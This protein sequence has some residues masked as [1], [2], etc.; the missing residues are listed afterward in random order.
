[1]ALATHAAL[2]VDA[3]R[4]EGFAKGAFT[5]TA[6][7]GALAPTAPANARLAKMDRAARERELFMIAE[8]VDSLDIDG[9]LSLSDVRDILWRLEDARI[10]VLGIGSYR[11][12]L[13]RDVVRETLRE[14]RTKTE[15]L[16]VLAARK[17]AAGE[18]DDGGDV[19]PSQRD[20]ICQSVERDTG[21]FDAIFRRDVKHL[22]EA[23]DTVRTVLLAG[24]NADVAVFEVTG[25]LNVLRR[26]KCYALPHVSDEI[27][28]VLGEEWRWVTKR[29]AE[30]PAAEGPGGESKGI[31]THDGGLKAWLTDVRPYSQDDPEV[32]ERRLRDASKIVRDIDPENQVGLSQV[33]TNLERLEMCRNMAAESITS[34]ADPAVLKK[35]RDILFMVKEKSG[36]LKAQAEQREAAGEVDDV[37]CLM[38]SE[39]DNICKNI[40]E[41]DLPRALRGE[42]E[43]VCAALDRLHRATVDRGADVDAAIAHVVGTLNLL[44]K[45]P[46]DRAS[47]VAGK[48][49]IVF[50]EEWRLLGSVVESGAE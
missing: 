4:L 7:A 49:E 30:R 2:R 16:N 38:P 24:E 37:R 21:V 50:T 40:T 31:E 29:L 45:R 47:G 14:I 19:P 36:I 41:L 39:R 3:A 11:D 27:A 25:R 18:L 43:D 12:H 35:V 44:K 46:D 17:V 48:L 42:V 9:L 13:H 23:L 6:A 10:I 26:Q 33:R 1:V 34:N 8:F 20:N 28:F 32:R 22:C 15:T 5:S